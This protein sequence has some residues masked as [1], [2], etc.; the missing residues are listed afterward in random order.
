M[1]CSHGLPQRTDMLF[2]WPPSEN[3]RANLT[4]S[5]REQ[6][7]HSRGLPQRTDTSFSWSPSENRRTVFMVSLREQTRLRPDRATASKVRQ[8]AQADT[9]CVQDKLLLPEH[10]S[11]LARV[12]CARCILFLHLGRVQGHLWGENTRLSWKVQ[13][14]LWGENTRPS[15]QETTRDCLKRPKMYTHT[16]MYYTHCRSFMITL[17]FFSLFFS[18]SGDPVWLTRC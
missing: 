13:G 3:R 14:H 16:Y 6:T 9:R 12:L 5:L 15:S 4:V 17:H 10:Y 1:H 11:S 2:L 18:P 7:C 8:L